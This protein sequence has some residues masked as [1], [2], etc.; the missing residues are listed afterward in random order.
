MG[1]LE[2]GRTSLIWVCRAVPGEHVGG[3]DC[4]CSPYQLDPSDEVAVS[5]MLELA[6]HPERQVDG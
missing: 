6:D 1:E 4:W 3:P 5:R 2:S